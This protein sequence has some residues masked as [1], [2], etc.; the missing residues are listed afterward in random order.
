MVEEEEVHQS[1]H[2]S[3]QKKKPM[4]IDIPDE[5]NESGTGIKENGFHLY[6][7]SVHDSGEGLPYAP[8]DWPNPG[9]NW[10]W[11]VGK[12]VAVSG[13][14]LD[15]YLYLP[16]RFQQTS[17]KR[18]GFASKLSVEQY[19]RAEFPGADIDAFFASFSWKIPSKKPSEIKGNEDELGT[20]KV[21]SEKITEHSG[22]DS[23]FGTGGC[24]AGNKMCSSLVE[25]GNPSSEV[26]VCNIC[27]SE[28]GFC[29]DCCCILCSRTINWDYGGYSFIKCEGMIGEGFICGHIAH[30]EC[31]LR[32]YMAGTVGGS[33]GLDAEYYCRRCDTRT[34]LV[35]HVSKL[36]QTCQSIESRDEIEKILSIGVCILRGSQKTSAMMLLHR[37]ELAMAKLKRGM[38]LE[39]LW[40][41]EDITA[42]TAATLP[43]SAAKKRLTF[44]EEQV[45]S[46]PLL[47]EDLLSS[48]N[49]KEIASSAAAAD[50]MDLSLPSFD[51]FPL[52]DEEKKRAEALKR[53]ATEDQPLAVSRFTEQEKDVEEPPLKKKVKQIPSSTSKGKGVNPSKSKG[54]KANEDD[55][56]E[57]IRAYVLAE[58]REPWRPTFSR[59]D[60]SVL[61]S[62]D[63]VVTD[64]SAA[65]A[66]ARGMWLPKDEEII[67][68]MGLDQLLPSAPVHA[69]ENMYHTMALCAT[70]EAQSIF[71]RKM[72]KELDAA[73]KKLSHALTDVKMAYDARD[74]Y[75]SRLASAEAKVK[76]LEAENLRWRDAVNT[77]TTAGKQMQGRYSSLV[78][79]SSAR[80]FRFGFNQGSGDKLKDPDA[81]DVDME[82]SFPYAEGPKAQEAEVLFAEMVKSHQGD[83]PTS[84][85][86]VPP[87]PS[88]LVPSASNP[89]TPPDTASNP[90][91]V[92]VFDSAP[93]DPKRK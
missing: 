25:L 50:L 73:E 1:Y 78:R 33:I 88:P 89:S 59:A 77:C 44:L 79:L 58:A 62:G 60:K 93:F 42:V 57:E 18:S 31:G 2:W 4:E 46:D 63:S 32:S 21:L 71:I 52:T 72:E 56:E 11:R 85:S 23:Q 13:Y 92:D 65:L 81:F 19:I 82:V 54:K 36:L 66:I 75:K 10:S 53:K 30:I 67:G 64:P 20:V 12:R 6:P 74:V 76:E 90:N 14:F 34:D 39:D 15:R 80:A 70:A 29:R 86:S 27:C 47:V 68:N 69:M 17:R 45:W 51:S 49:L 9:D 83:P 43:S 5:S 84:T 38:H 35:S 26:M 41:M 61:H 24:K 91:V 48:S 28:P 8:I 22:S 87:A 7:V 55:P 3:T 40:K 37:I 16:S